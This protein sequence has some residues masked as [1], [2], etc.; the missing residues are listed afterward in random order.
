MGR[1]L[2]FRLD[3]LQ[4][5]VSALCNGAC[6]YCPQQCYRNQWQGGLMDWRTFKRLEPSFSKTDLVY[7][8]GWGEPLLHP[9]IWQM[10]RHVTRAG[11]AVGFTTNGTLLDEGNLE[12]LIEHEVNVVGI[13]LA[14]TRPATHERFRPS[15]K[16]QL[17]DEA[18]T[19]LNE[20]KR[21]KRTD[22]P[23]VH[24]AFLL[25]RSNLEEVGGLVDLASRWGA[26]Q[27]VVSNLSWIA[28]PEM[29]EESTLLD[30][31]IW[32]RVAEVLARARRHASSKGMLLHYYGSG[33]GEPNSICPE[34]VLKAC[35]VSH[36]GNVSPCVFANLSLHAASHV[37]QYF[38]GQPWRSA[39][40]IFGNIHEQS[41]PEIWNS[42]KAKQLRRTFEDRLPIE[43]PGTN[44]L[45]AA[46]TRCYRLR[47][48]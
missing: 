42:D 25:L 23:H 16:F 36:N 12:R 11:A 6:T 38:D 29:Q 35:F 1:R 7:L 14:G 47:E 20:L 43:H 26:S 44:E 46:C 33:M 34:N 3:W 17:I 22:Y 48:R 31:E 13:S 28:G 10:V 5:E 2:H 4:V 15:C 19:A 32:P 40:I 37:S 21:K 41:L 39:P 45:P 24:L 30:P 18:L 9:D 8:Q 27:V